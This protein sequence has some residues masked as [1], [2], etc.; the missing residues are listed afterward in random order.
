MD[1]WA[2]WMSLA[3][4]FWIF[5]IVITQRRV[6]RLRAGILTLEKARNETGRIIMEMSQMG[7][8]DPNREQHE[9]KARDS[10]VKYWNIFHRLEK[11]A[12]EFLK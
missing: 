1:R 10:I 12:D 3:I 9:A 5:D 2:I 7:E 11:D 6:G 8:F 4:T